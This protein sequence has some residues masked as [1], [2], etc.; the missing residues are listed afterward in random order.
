MKKEIN[1]Y[2]QN[3]F[4][5]IY[6]IDYKEVEKIIKKTGIWGA[7]DIDE[8]LLKD[9]KPGDIGFLYFPKK[10]ELFGVFVALSKIGLYDPNWTDSKHPPDKLKVQVKLQPFREPLKIIQASKVLKPQNIIEKEKG[11]PKSRI[12]SNRVTAN[13]IKSFEIDEKKIVLEI[14]EEEKVEIYPKFDEIIGLEKAKKFI[15]ERIILPYGH[16]RLR[17]LIKFR[18]GGGIL[19]VGPPGTGKTILA[20]ATARGLEC[21]FIEITPADIEG[22]PGEAEKKLEE[23]FQRACK[24]PRAVLFFDEA[25]ALLRKESVSSVIP[26][27]KSQLLR[28]FS[29]IFEEDRYVLIMAATNKPYEI[30]EAFLRPKRFDQIIYVGLPTKENLKKLLKL[31]LEKRIIPQLISLTEQDYDKLSDK[32][33]GFTGADIEKLV[34]CVCVLMVK[35]L[36]EKLKLGNIYEKSEL[37][38]EIVNN[39]KLT[40]DKIETIIE[41]ERIAP[42]VSEIM[43]N[44]IK[45]WC[46]ERN[47]ETD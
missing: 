8:P 41:K 47:I 40:I 2:E 17:K 3:C 37:N 6:S 15:E 5:M 19:M 45:K 20:K 14:E 16:Q 18:I 22:F 36:A 42:S 12:Y 21:E 4:F 26:R 30:D 9:I 24:L 44:E 25:D 27:I 11:F 13:I 34:D 10:D 35:N 7:F 39:D 1:P 38:D 33:Q 23:T 31:K 43:L 32:L 29:M 28:L 46:Q